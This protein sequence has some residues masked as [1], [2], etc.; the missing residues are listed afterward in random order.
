MIEVFKHIFG[1]ISIL[2][3][4]PHSRTAH[5]SIRN[6]EK[7]SFALGLS[8]NEFFRV[9]PTRSRAIAEQKLEKKK[10]IFLER[11]SGGRTSIF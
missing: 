4:K 5:G 10:I 11:S 1:T 9:G 6:P 7:M 2:R 8:K 3:N